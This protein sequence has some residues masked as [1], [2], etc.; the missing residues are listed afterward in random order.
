MSGKKCN[1]VKI[2]IIYNKY[3]YEFTDEDYNC[4]SGFF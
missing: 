2:E 3:R 1:F 4:G